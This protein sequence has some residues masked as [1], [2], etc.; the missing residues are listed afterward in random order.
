MKLHPRI[1]V[2]EGKMDV[3]TKYRG[4]MKKVLVNYVKDMEESLK[5]ADPSMVFL[6]H[7]GVDGEILETIRQYLASL[8]HFKE[9]HEAIAG[10]VISSHCGPGSLGVMFYQK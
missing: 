1:E 4:K 8:N 10:G 7:S 6:T 5:A 2:N 9:I 3:G